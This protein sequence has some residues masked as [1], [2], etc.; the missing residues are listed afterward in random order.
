MLKKLGRGLDSLI[1]ATAPRPIG[2]E[3]ERREIPCSSIRPNPHQPREILDDEAIR[4][5]ADSIRQHGILQPL[6]VRPADDGY[7]LVAGERRW[8]AS[9]LLGRETVPVVVRRV[10]DDQMLEIAL[11]ENLQREDL[12]AIEKARAYRRFLTE[13]A[14]THE[15]AAR[16]LGKDRSSITNH[17]RL[18]ELSDEIQAMVSRGTLSMGHARALLSVADETLRGKLAARIAEEGLSVRATERLTKENGKA[19]P[20]PPA[21]RSEE[22]SAHFDDLERQIR[23]RYATR[24]RIDGT[25]E[26]GRISLE[27]YSLEELD[28]VLELLLGS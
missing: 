4:E 18:L 26:R 3:D 15:E 28:R 16:R 6:L 12:N 20:K 8:R 13:L 2:G 27:Y 14:L 23:E 10:T 11:V 22:R 17:L 1:E 25:R 9:R 7:E 5:L 24:A 19:S 21:R